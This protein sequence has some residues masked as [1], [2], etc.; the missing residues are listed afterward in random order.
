M[1]SW[2]RMLTEYDKSLAKIEGRIAELEKEIKGVPKNTDA[3]F[4]L[5]RRILWLEAE[6]MDLIYSI[7]Q[8]RDRG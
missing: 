4:N 6:Q 8:I 3:W 7:Q 2:D 1:Q 5:T